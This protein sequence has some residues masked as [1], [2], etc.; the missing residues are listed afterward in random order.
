MRALREEIAAGRYPPQEAP[1]V[2]A[3]GNADPSRHNLPPTRTSFV[4]RERELLEVKRELASTRLLTLAGAGGAGK[5]RLAEEVVRDLAGAYP[6]GAWMVGLA[7]L[8][9]DNLVVRGWRAS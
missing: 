3:S 9:Q 8:S 7:P 1:R 6:G 2:L 5:T 4:G